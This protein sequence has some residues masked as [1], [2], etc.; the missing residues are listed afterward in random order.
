MSI[1]NVDINS[2]RNKF[3]IEHL[4]KVIS[5]YWKEVSE[6]ADYKV[7]KEWA[8]RIAK[9]VSQSIVNKVISVPDSIENDALLTCLSNQEKSY[10][11]STL[12][13]EALIENM[14]SIFWYPNN[15]YNDLSQAVSLKNYCANLIGKCRDAQNNPFLMH[16]DQILVGLFLLGPNQLY[17]AHQHPATE[18]WVVLSGRAKWQRGDEPWV[19]REPGEYFVHASNE[20][21]AMETMD[22]PLL[23]MWAWTGDLDKWAQWVE[24]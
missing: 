2:E 6:K 11:A 20:S 10:E 23:A 13:K 1:E 19:I 18:G 8:D 21:H 14:H 17:P 15:V 4:G 9:E 3:K 7:N 24:Q 12:L 5:E 22:E 16:N